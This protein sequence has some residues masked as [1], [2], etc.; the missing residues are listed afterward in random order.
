MTLDG[1][2]QKRGGDAKGTFHKEENS[3]S[4][5]EVVLKY[6]VP[7]LEAIRAEL[8]RERASGRTPEPT[9]TPAS[10]TIREPSPK[11]YLLNMDEVSERLSISKPTLYR[12]TSERRIPFYKIGGRVLFAEEKLKEWLDRYLVDMV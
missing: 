7:A 9:Q 5:T 6:L 3:M 2:M 11:K 12:F 10:V 1:D 8:E 4:T